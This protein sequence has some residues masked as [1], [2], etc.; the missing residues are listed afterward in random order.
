MPRTRTSGNWLHAAHSSWGDLT[1]LIDDYFDT[2]VGPK[3]AP[4]SYA[5][6]AES[7]GRSAETLLFVSDVKGE[8]DAARQGGFRA[9]L[10]VRSA[11]DEPPRAD[12]TTIRSFAEIR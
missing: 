4:D 8:V 3:Q 7:M 6:I 10:C 11:A 1:P 12:V 5:R 2:G 9:L